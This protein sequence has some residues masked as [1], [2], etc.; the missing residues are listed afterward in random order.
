MTRSR[1]GIISTW[2][3]TRL[4]A[5]NTISSN[6]F[7]LNGCLASANPAIAEIRMVPATAGIVMRKLFARKRPA[8][9]PPSTVA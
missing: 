9:D 1:T 4:P 6:R 3:G 7:P 5:T 2:N 8:R